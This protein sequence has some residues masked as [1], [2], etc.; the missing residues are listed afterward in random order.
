MYRVEP[1]G[2]QLYTVRD[3]MAEDAP[4]T[5]A[6]IAE[7]G[8]QEVETAGYADLSPREF[9]A[10][11][12]AVGLRAPS[13]VVALE[14]VESEPDNL[15][16]AAQIVGHQYLVMPWLTEQQR[17]RLDQYHRVADVLNQFG[18]KCASAGIQL[19]YH[20]HDF[21]FVQLDDVIPY[22]LLLDRCDAG[23]V[24]MELD[25]FWATKAGVNPVEYFNAWPDRF[26]LCHVKDMNA[27]G[28]MVA[29]GEGVIDFAELF[30]AGQKGG[31]GH[32]FVE[33]DYPIDALETLSTSYAA[34]DA[35]RY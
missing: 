6:R 15:I 23:L 33:H 26:P 1:I 35:I 32:F 21:E 30:K 18:E 34:V 7:I 31:L 16:E 20:N 10:A 25:L 4:G 27:R 2:V 19:A 24:K 11:L 9:A 8:Y 13:A 22:D 12:S 29:V 28:E 14:S 5:L 17:E 3:L